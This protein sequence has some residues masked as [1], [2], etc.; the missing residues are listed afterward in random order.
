MIPWWVERHYIGNRWVRIPGLRQTSSENRSAVQFEQ[1]KRSDFVNKLAGERN[2]R[3]ESILVHEIL[4]QNEFSAM[5]IRGFAYMRSRPHIPFIYSCLLCQRNPKEK[6]SVLTAIS[7]WLAL[8]HFL[9]LS[10]VLREHEP[11]SCDPGPLAKDPQHPLRPV[12]GDHVA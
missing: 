6:L 1:C 3:L 8:C 5:K 7:D 2:A 4:S 11:H 9:K 12:C 10:C